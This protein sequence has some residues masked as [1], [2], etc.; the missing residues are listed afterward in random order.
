MTLAKCVRIRK[1]YGSAAVTD[2]N[3]IRCLKIHYAEGKEIFR[4]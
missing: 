1:R 4:K 3:N 2:V